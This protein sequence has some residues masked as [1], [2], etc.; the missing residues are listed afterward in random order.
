M[1]SETKKKSKNTL[2][3]PNKNNL[4][5]RVTSTVNNVYDLSDHGSNQRNNL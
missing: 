1:K 2:R 5:Q 3:A 4:M